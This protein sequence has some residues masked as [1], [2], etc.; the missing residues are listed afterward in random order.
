MIFYII[1]I[2]KARQNNTC[3]KISLM[4]HQGRGFVH[5]SIKPNVFLFYGMKIACVS[6]DKRTFTNQR[7]K[8]KCF[9]E[10][11]GISADVVC[12]VWTRIILLR[13]EHIPKGAE[14]KHLLWA[15]LFMKVYATE[16]ILCSLA[17]GV[18]KDTFR[19]WRN[20]FIDEIARLFPYEVRI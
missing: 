13:K 5:G 14:P 8:E 18:D 19:K 15:L 9:I 11:F 20:I 4:L 3:V 17:G 7:D 6:Q 16:R 10:M 1:T 12:D 2:D